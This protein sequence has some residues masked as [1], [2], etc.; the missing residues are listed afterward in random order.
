[1]KKLWNWLLDKTV[2]A[3]V[4]VITPDMYIRDCHYGSNFICDLDINDVMDLFPAYTED[5]LSDYHEPEDFNNFIEKEGIAGFLL[6][7][8]SLLFEGEPPRYLIA[9]GEDDAIDKISKLIAD[10]EG[11]QS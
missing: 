1:M 6:I 3:T 4:T 7:E 2:L 5:E 11:G 9:S 10:M 8:I